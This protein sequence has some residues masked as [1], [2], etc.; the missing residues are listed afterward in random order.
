MKIRLLFLTFVLIFTAAAMLLCQTADIWAT[1]PPT[2]NTTTPDTPTS[3][4]G[5]NAL[6][7]TVP[8]TLLGPSSQPEDTTP[9]FIPY[10]VGPSK[11][12]KSNITANE[13]WYLN[14]D[15]NM[16][17]WLYIYEYFTLGEDLSGRWIAYKW[18]L[19]QSGV[20]RLGPF[21]PEDNEPEGQ[22]IYRIWFYSDGQWAEENPDA[23][24]NSFVYWT[25]SK[26]QPTEQPTAQ[27]PSQPLTPPSKEAIFSDKLYEFITLRIVLVLGSLLLLI[28]IM[29][30]LYIYWRYG[31]RGN[32]QTAEA[33]DEVKTQEPAAILPSGV[34]GA[35]IA[36]PN[37]AEISLAN[38]RVIGRG[39]LARALSLD[40]LGLISRQHFEI[41]YED[42]QFYI[43]DLGSANGTKLNGEDISG[44]GPV[45]LHNDDLIEPA[46]AIK[47]KFILL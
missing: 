29:L 41:K 39:D 44:K 22:H 31:R 8:S 2:D 32:G 40:E 37:G 20:W 18:Q 47:L 1:G 28:I 13:K 5:G 15:I 14:V 46:C 43:E 7:P 24:Q 23:P 35:K 9:S 27:T 12:D 19:T 26:G 3:G 6:A 25:Y 4:E 42:E 17:G 10:F 11:E 30:G 36:L 33:I 45:S 16:P 38:N 21:A 34:A